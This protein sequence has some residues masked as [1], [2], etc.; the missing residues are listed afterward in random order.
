MP[1]NGIPVFLGLFLLFWDMLR[2]WLP[3]PSPCT[4][5]WWHLGLW[6]GFSSQDVMAGPVAVL[7][8]LI[9]L[10]CQG[11]LWW[12]WSCLGSWER[13]PWLESYS[14][15]VSSTLS[16]VGSCFPSACLALLVPG[17][18]MWGLLDLLHTAQ[19]LWR[20][21]QH[22]GSRAQH[23]HPSPI[24]PCFLFS[25]LYQGSTEQCEGVL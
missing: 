21:T 6:G 9:G 2:F 4:C 10:C 13:W 25:I 11:L 22:P 24:N 5:L 14:C 18:G 12:A 20:A 15:S 8:V 1:I 7:W 16:H 3:L 23:P 17:W 19:G